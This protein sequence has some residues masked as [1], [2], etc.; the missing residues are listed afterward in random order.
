M[1]LRF[2]FQEIAN[3]SFFLS[4]CSLYYVYINH[5]ICT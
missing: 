1:Y 3:L 2:Q 5:D 4:F